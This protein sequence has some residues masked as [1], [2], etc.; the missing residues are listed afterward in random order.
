MSR[1]EQAKLFPKR[2]I[3]MSMADKYM[4]VCFIYDG[5]QYQNLCKEENPDGTFNYSEKCLSTLS[6]N[7]PFLAHDSFS[8]NSSSNTQSGLIR[9]RNP[10][11]G[12]FPD[13]LSAI[14]HYWFEVA[15]LC[16]IS[17]L[18]FH[19]AFILTRRRSS[20]YNYSNGKISDQDYRT[21]GPTVD[22]EGTISIG[23]IA[24]NPKSVLG[25][26]SKGTCVFKGSYEKSQNCAVKRIVSQYLS[27]AD[28]EIEFLRS[29]QDPHLV[30]YLAT[31]Q[32]AQFIYIALEM[33]EFNLAELVETNRISSTGLDRQELCRQAAMGLAYL[34]KLNI[35]HRDIKPHNI[36]ISFP[37][38]PSNERKVMIS[39]FGL[40]KQLGLM[41]TCAT[42]SA[43]RWFDG[44]QGW[45]APEIVSAKLK[46]EK[47]LMPTKSADIF[48]LGCVFYY[49][50]SNGKHPFGQQ[51]ERQSNILNNESELNPFKS[52]CEKNIGLSEDISIMGYKL[53]E[54]MIQHE[55]NNRPPIATIL[56]YPL[57]W[58]RSDQLQFLQDVSDR[59]DKEENTSDVIR[60]IERDRQKIFGYDWKECLSQDLQDDLGNFRGYN[61]RSVRHLLRAIRN[62]R[63]H[64][65]ELPD[66][67]KESLG[68]V[69][70]GFM[71]Y[72]SS[73]FPELLPHVYHA[74]QICRNEGVLRY[75]YEQLEDYKFMSR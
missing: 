74:M 68:E 54:S 58:P 19:L 22:E 30:R 1:S 35:V 42:S 69:P 2:F 41:D 13:I 64:Y 18:T 75:Y 60:L 47:P 26:G 49:I 36:L 25:L 27:I 32:D 71:D 72:F 4:A 44:T 43:I 37:T 45:M 17:A 61:S 65:R 8:S 55:P 73:R 5:I 63:H 57:F 52:L 50:M 38:K 34:H 59:I 9:Y 21:A 15:L 3:T 53:I 40:S 31:E 11:Q 39:D 23:K 51:N 16:V 67:L 56:K 29:L 10:D 28:R 7:F 33:A 48:S 46:D 6:Q 66:E 14:S 20:R 70:D 12:D 24:F 62:K